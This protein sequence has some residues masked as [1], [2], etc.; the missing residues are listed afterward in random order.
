MDETASSASETLW[1]EEYEIEPVQTGDINNNKG[2]MYCRE[3]PSCKQSLGVAFKNVAAHV[4]YGD[5]YLHDTIRSAPPNAFSQ[6]HCVSCSNISPWS[7]WVSNDLVEG[8]KSMYEPGDEIFGLVR[9]TGEGRRHIDRIY[10]FVAKT[11]TDGKVRW[12]RER[13]FRVDGVTS[14][15]TLRQYARIHSGEWPTS[16][17]K[18]RGL[19]RTKSNLA[20]QAVENM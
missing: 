16:R 3:C 2:Y 20:V 12:C 11:G 13:K 10:L 8:Q 17:L 18:H 9:R 1:E 5:L 19:V 7:E 15:A 14:I 4:E 6:A